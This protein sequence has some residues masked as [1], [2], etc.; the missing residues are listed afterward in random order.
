MIHRPATLGDVATFSHFVGDCALSAYGIAQT[1]TA[2][3]T[4]DGDPVMLHGQDQF[5]GPLMIPV[6]ET[7]QA[8]KIGFARYSKRHRQDFPFDAMPLPHALPERTE[9]WAHWLNCEMTCPS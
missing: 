9:A 6:V 3:F 5:G 4:D 2:V 7:I 1:L 8:H